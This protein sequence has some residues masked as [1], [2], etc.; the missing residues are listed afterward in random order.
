MNNVSDEPVNQ[1][2]LC[3]QEPIRFPGCIQPHGVF[4][5]VDSASR[6]VLAVSENFLMVPR[7]FQNPCGR[8]LDDV[9]PELGSWSGNGAYVTTDGHLIIKNSDDSTIYYDV[10]PCCSDDNFSNLSLVDVAEILDELSQLTA[11]D[12]VLNALTH[13]I[14]H[15]TGMERVIVYRFDKDGHGEVLAESKVDD[16]SESFLGFHFPSADIPSQARQ[17]YLVNKYRYAPLRDYNPVPITPKNDQRTGMP[18][19]LSPSQLRSVSQVH[20]HYQ[21]NLGVDGSMSISIV[22]E[23]QLW[24][25]VVG[26]HRRPHRVPIPARQ[27]VMALIAGLAMRLSPIETAEERE[28]RARPVVLHTQLLEQIAWQVQDYS[29]EHSLHSASLP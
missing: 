29:L 3:E 14:L 8:L 19:D 1:Q 24:G 23:G 12:Q 11:L 2:D 21:E 20:R 15:I 6:R 10:E 25:L 4:F 7:F 22:S 27:Q 16:W 18:F 17:L 28:A 13:E 26:H 9:W 5:C